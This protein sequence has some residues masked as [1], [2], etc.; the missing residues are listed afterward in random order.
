MD[1]YQS[2]N[3]G[4]GKKP[5]KSDNG[6]FIGGMAVGVMGTLLVLCVVVMVVWFAKGEK[7]SNQ[8]GG[9][10]SS[11]KTAESVS[12]YGF[13]TD[14]MVKKIDRLVST[15]RSKYFL[16][17]VSDEDLETGIYRGLMDSLGDPYTEYYTPQEYIELMQGSEGIYY[18]IGAVVSMDSETNLPKIGTVFKNSP[19][20]AAGVRT[21]DLVYMVDGELTTGKTLSE[22]VSHIR[23]DEN[24]KVVLTVIRDG[25][26]LE[27]TA[28][29]G[30]VENPTVETKDLGN[31]MGYLQITEF[32]DVTTRQ[33]LEGMDELYQGGMQGLILDLRSNPGG[34]LSTVVEIAQNLLPQGLVVYT[35][36]KDGKRSEYKCKGDK[37]I[38]IPLVV[39]VDMNSASASE[40]LAGA[41]QDYQK[42]TLVGTTTY[43]KGIVQT[44][45]PAKDGSAIKITV[46]AYFT[47]KGR[48]I[49][50]IGIEPDIV[51]EFD[52]EKYYDTENP[53]DNQ[54]EK[55]KEVLA[56][57]MGR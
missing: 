1:S 54:L 49:H 36:T 23:G 3:V 48:N 31:G 53:I 27:L 15:I 46:S 45:L 52:S 22:V 29:R 55:A 4:G 57:L 21:N 17:E 32:D 47:P 50:K 41:I 26:E 38:K 34:N 35:E 10:S 42:G 37:E 6:A 28:T 33:F 18:G 40:I 12:G 20:E 5:K 13:V 39:L 8:G 43:G 7:A 56:G 25:E 2:R 44:I 14:D 11:Q 19:A 51:C 9:G 16:E 30:R 24:T